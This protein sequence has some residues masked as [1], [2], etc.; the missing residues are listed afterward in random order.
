MKLSV[1]IIGIL[2]LS[3]F[4]IL[5]REKA[6]IEGLVVNLIATIFSGLIL[7]FLFFLAREKIFTLPNISGQWYI[8][9]L[10]VKTAYRPY[11]KMKLRYVAMLW[12]EGNHIQGTVEKIYEAST[13]G[14]RQF[15]GKNRTRGELR[16]YVQKNY[17]SK[18]RVYLHVVEKGHGRESSHIYEIDVQSEKKMVGTFTSM[19]ADQS[20]EVIWQREEF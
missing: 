16:G 13:T 7:A 17:L 11:N 19:V 12:R 20:G 1:V 8:E 14:I 3:I 10:T 9:M 4:F 15:T 2:V 18:D 6:L 5:P